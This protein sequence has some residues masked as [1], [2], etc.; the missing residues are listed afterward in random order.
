V[1]EPTRAEPDCRCPR[2]RL[3]ATDLATAPRNWSSSCPRHGVDTRWYRTG[4]RDRLTTGAL[5]T[6]N[7]G[8]AD[9]P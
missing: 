1:N 9:L 7:L 8:P 2:V 3:G 4:G 5:P 6:R